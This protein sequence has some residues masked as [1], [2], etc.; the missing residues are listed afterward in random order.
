MRGWIS[1]IKA[2]D[3]GLRNLPK[4]FKQTF[5]CMSNAPDVHTFVH[6]KMV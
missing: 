2:I 6:G 1:S 3:G 5:S 4:S